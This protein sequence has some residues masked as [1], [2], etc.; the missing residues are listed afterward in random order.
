MTP[1]FWAIISVGVTLFIGLGGLILS[2]FSRIDRL[3]Q[4][5]DD[6]HR[7]LGQRIVELEKKMAALSATVEMYFSIRLVS[8]PPQSPDSKQRDQ[9]A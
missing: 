1:E 8:P 7:E 4:R 3:D 6:N 2:I 5:V 9:A